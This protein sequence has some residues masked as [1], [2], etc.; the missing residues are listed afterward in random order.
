MYAVYPAYDHPQPWV[1]V[2]KNERSLDNSGSPGKLRSNDHKKADEVQKEILDNS[3]SQPDSRS[4]NRE[5]QYLNSNEQ[6][7]LW[8][9]NYVSFL[10]E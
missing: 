3:N 9:L 8:P 5:G 1:D 4:N 7:H 2:W 10:C 6:T